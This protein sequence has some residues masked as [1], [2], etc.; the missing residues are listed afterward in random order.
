MEKPETASKIF[1]SENWNKIQKSYDEGEA[2]KGLAEAE[3]GR[4]SRYL[5]W[6]NNKIQTVQSQLVFKTLDF[7]FI[8]FFFFIKWTI[9]I[10]E[11][12]TREW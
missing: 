3:K 10:N 5:F 1:N 7:S 11:M 6:K 12:K 9:I 4:G 8:L 2:T